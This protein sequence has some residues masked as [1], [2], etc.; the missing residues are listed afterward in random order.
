MSRSAHCAIRFDENVEHWAAIRTSARWE[1]RAAEVLAAVGIPVFLPTWTR[2]TKY[3]TR[4]NVSELPLFSGYLFFDETR[5]ADLSQ[6]AP[7]S[8]RY[9]AQVLKP[10]DHAVLRAEL[11]EIAKLI[12]DPNRILTKVYGA[13]GE[14]VRITR[15]SFRGLEGRIV[16]QVPAS[17]RFVLTVSFLG[18]SVEVEV[19][20]RAVQKVI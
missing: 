9:V 20:D 18:L 11:R 12:A 7:P 3:A 6:L 15:G 8:K 10:P 14:P 13:P 4:T 17:S 19:E 2:V 16:R 1:K 5:L